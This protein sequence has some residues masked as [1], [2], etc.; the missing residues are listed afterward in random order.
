[1]CVL[2]RHWPRRPESR[3]ASLQNCRLAQIQRAQFV[4]YLPRRAAIHALSG[5]R[6]RDS[7]NGRYSPTGVHA[8]LRRAER[9]SVAGCRNAEYRF[10]LRI[11][12][13]FTFHPSSLSMYR[14]RPVR[15][16]IYP[17]QI[18]IR[19]AEDETWHTN[20]VQRSAKSI[21]RKKQ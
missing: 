21:L 20:F 7:F 5:R 17:V 13:L 6:P 16:Q 2:R 10:G 14:T 15:T 12:L 19:L 18:T 11:A 3:K 4:E 1:M 9:A 8:L